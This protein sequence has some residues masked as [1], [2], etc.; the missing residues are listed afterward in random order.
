M[1]RQ[2]DLGAEIKLTVQVY[3]QIHD[4]WEILGFR[5]G[6]FRN[7]YAA[8]FCLMLLSCISDC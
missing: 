8:R 1:G 3:D 2:G 4:L 6:V 5:V 7:M